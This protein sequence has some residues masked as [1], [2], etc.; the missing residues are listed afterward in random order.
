MD[1]K[2]IASRVTLVASSGTVVHRWLAWIAQ[3]LA[4]VS[5]AALIVVLPIRHSWLIAARPMPPIYD[6]YTNLVLYPS[7]LALVAL[8]ISWL[9]NLIVRPRRIMSGPRFLS[10]PLAGLTLLG[11]ISVTYSVDPVLSLYHALRLSALLGLYLYL[12]NEIRSLRLVAVAA[13]GQVTLQ[14]IIGIVEVL[15][16]H[17][18]GLESLGEHTLDPAW[19][20]VSV[21]VANGIRSLRAYALT[22]HPNILG[23]CLALGLLLIVAWHI[24]S[25]SRWSAA[26]GG[27]FAIGSVGLLLT[28]SRSAWM[29]LSGGAL[30]IAA[31]LIVTRQRWRIQRWLS[32]MIV[33]LIAALPFA[34]SNADYLGVR[35]NIN[36]SFVTVATEDQALGERTILNGLARGMIA[37]RP[38]GV[39]LGTFPIALQQREPNYPF[40]YQP[41]HHVLLEAASELGVIGGSLYFVLIVAPWIAL[42]VK[43]RWVINSPGLIGLSGLLL[44]VS[45]IGVFDYYTWLGMPGRLWLWLIWGLWGAMYQSAQRRTA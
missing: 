21:V 13:M 36:N 16:Q 24:S 33:G 11:L 9:L 26:V 37:D 41:P 10:W 20:G 19:Q 39:G 38:W 3:V 42:I 44:A 30:A 32:L 27:I 2:L 40:N 15:R 31:M 35:L 23:G 7:D 5:L 1:A 29:A 6:G 34:I 18:I 25:Y 14:A 28:F 4:R 45:V 8:L 43:R 22:D 12:V 17:S